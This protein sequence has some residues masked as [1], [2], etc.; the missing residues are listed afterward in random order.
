MLY[1]QPEY[2][3]PSF[4]SRHRIHLTRQPTTNV[5]NPSQGSPISPTLKEEARDKREPPA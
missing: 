5:L 3:L 1:T 2:R 4:A